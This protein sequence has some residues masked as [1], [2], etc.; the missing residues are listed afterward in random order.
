MYWV[1]RTRIIYWKN[2][3]VQAKLIQP[4]LQ[5]LRQ[6]YGASGF[7]DPMQN[8]PYGTALSLIY[9]IDLRHPHPDNY[10]QNAGF[11][12]YSERLVELMS[13]FGVKAE[14][15]PITMVDKQNEG[16]PELQYFVFHSLEGVLQ[17][18]DEERSKWTG[19][20]DVGVPRLIL[21][22]TKFEHRPIF[23]CNH[24]YVPLMRDD[25]KQEIQRQG[26]TGFAFLSPERYRSGSYGFP[27]D[28]DE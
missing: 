28:F 25:L 11:T 27:P 24:L 8:E 2:Q 15:F 22:E 12:L 19:D 17:A 14:V 1:F 4:K 18:M 10:F 20:H 23:V 3:Q 9:Q 16:L 7:R 13:S 6:M 5:D 21:D 26:I